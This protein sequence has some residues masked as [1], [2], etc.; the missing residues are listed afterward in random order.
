MEFQCQTTTGPV[1]LKPFY[2]IRDE[3]YSTYLLLS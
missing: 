3:V 2:Q 1:R